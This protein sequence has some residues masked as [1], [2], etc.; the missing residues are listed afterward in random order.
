[1]VF[2]L[3]ISM[4]NIISLISRRLAAIGS[5]LIYH[6]LPGIFSTLNVYPLTLKMKEVFNFIIC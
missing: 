6:G 1:V 2:F 5:G 3:N 4:K